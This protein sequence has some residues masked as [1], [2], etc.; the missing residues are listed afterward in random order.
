MRDSAVKKLARRYAHFKQQQ[1]GNICVCT[2]LRRLPSLEDKVII[3]I[4]ISNIFS[5]Y[6]C[7]V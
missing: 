7:L 5:N 1:Q 4:G 3:G 2:V 6:H